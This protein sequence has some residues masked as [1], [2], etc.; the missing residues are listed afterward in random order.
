MT[1]TQSLGPIV[2]ACN[3]FCPMLGQIHEYLDY[4]PIDLR[5]CPDKE[6]FPEKFQSDAAKKMQP[7]SGA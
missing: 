2:Y 4:A 6:N 3:L 5:E 1:L 7:K